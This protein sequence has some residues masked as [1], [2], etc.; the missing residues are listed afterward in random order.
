MVLEGI[1]MML[2]KDGSHQY[3]STI[4]S[5][6]ENT[7]LPAGILGKSFQKYYGINKSLLDRIKA[8]SMRWNKLLVLIKWL[9][10]V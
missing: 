8:H 3:H 4:N 6:T 7:I 2:E 1:C 9:E 10:T 5:G